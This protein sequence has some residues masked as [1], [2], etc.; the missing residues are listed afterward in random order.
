MKL[1]IAVKR[2][3]QSIVESARDRF[4]IKIKEKLEDDECKC[5]AHEMH[6]TQDEVQ[7]VV[8]TSAESTLDHMQAFGCDALLTEFYLPKVN[9]GAYV[10]C[11]Y[12][13]ETNLCEDIKD[14]VIQQY[15]RFMRNVVDSENFP[16]A[17]YGKILLHEWSRRRKTI[18]LLAPNNPG[19]TV[20]YEEGIGY[21]CGMKSD[22]GYSYGFFKGSKNVRHESEEF[23]LHN[24]ENIFFTRIIEEI[25]GEMLK[26]HLLSERWFRD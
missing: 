19:K 14:P 8:Y 6:K 2:E 3:H 24:I 12:R 20:G 18:L 16:Y 5:G 23:W 13:K 7:A 1:L 10:D 17:P 9:S 21:I 22:F 25:P 4:L 15:L 11:L 26:M